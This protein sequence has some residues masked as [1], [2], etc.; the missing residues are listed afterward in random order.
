[1]A[2]L[3]SVLVECGFPNVMMLI[4]CVMVQFVF[5]FLLILRYTM[6]LIVNVMVLLLKH[7]ALLKY[8]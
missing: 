6:T 8:H 5:F 4:S 7:D 1:M 2:L 3:I